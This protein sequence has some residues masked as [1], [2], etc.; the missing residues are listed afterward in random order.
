MLFFSCSETISEAPIQK[1][2]F[3]STNNLAVETTPK[4]TGTYYTISK[5]AEQAAYVKFTK[6]LEAND[7]ITILAE[8]DHANNAKSVGMDLPFTKIVFF[9]NPYLGTPLI[10][11]NQLAGI[12]LPQKVLFYDNGSNN[13]L[14]LYNSTE[15][16]RTR[17][18]LDGVE[19]L[20]TIS[21]ALK[22]LVSDATKSEIME[23]ADQKVGMGEGVE[24]L[25]SN[26]S[27][28]ATYNT[29][30]SIVL[31]NPDLRIILELDHKANAASVGMELRPTRLIVFGNPNLGT[32]LMK[33]SQTIALDLPQKMLV[34]Q[35]AEGKVMVSYND[36][37]YFANRHELENSEEQLSTIKGALQTIA[38][39]AAGL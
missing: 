37:Y 33:D 14:A 29:L 22:K 31:N 6:S 15:Y 8:V 32:L 12:D 21:N 2:G 34:W 17:H 16:L 3:I 26:Q 27:F 35:N 38:N 20:S 1:A 9:G 24:S 5:V 7:A 13:G 23:V 39:S 10:Q 19:T 36:P 18:G 28:E 30:K 4:V 11:K 25:E